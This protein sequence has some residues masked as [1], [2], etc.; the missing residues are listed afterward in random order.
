MEGA[1]RVFAK[2]FS[3]S[4]LTIQ[5]SDPGEPS[6]VVTPSG[7]WCHVMFLT[8]ALTEIS[9]EGDILRCRVSDPTGV[10]E[11]VVG[12]IRAELF[13]MVRKIPVPSFLAIVGTAQ[14]YQRKGSCRLSVRP[15]SIQIVDRTVRDTWVARTAD[16][17][18]DRLEQLATAI[19]GQT[20]D[21]RS[22]TTV[23]HYRT[24]PEQVQEILEM[25]VFALS[26]IQISASRVQAPLN[27][28]ELILAIIKD[29]QGARGITIDEV[30]TLAGLKGISAKTTTEIIR[31][32]IRGDECYQPQKGTIKLL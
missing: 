31:D 2:E 14:M 21:P 6:W 24:T 11:V 16:L 19:R 32:L 4:T 18:L 29:H 20:I 9:E 27:P 15:D 17:T 10:F 28:G 23:K 5:K 22:Q 26:S 30:I 13:T 7:A 8:G 1:A 12:G 25:V 3:Q